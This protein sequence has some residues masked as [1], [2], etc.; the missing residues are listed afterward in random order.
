MRNLGWMYYNKIILRLAHHQNP[1]LQDLVLPEHFSQEKMGVNT[2]T[3]RA[4]KF[5]AYGANTVT[6][7][8]A[9]TVSSNTVVGTKFT[10]PKHGT[11]QS[12]VVVRLTCRICGPY[13]VPH[14]VS[15]LVKP[16]IGPCISPSKAVP[17]ATVLRS[18][19]HVLR[20]VHAVPYIKTPPNEINHMNNKK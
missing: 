20:H 18:V 16:C 4:R 2:C 19:I 10:R 14:T 3:V 11:V 13:T 6:A 12:S 1:I 7:R 8:I 15:V 17:T 9:P 5:R